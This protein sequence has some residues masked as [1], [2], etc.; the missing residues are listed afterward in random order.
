MSIEINLTIWVEALLPSG[1]DGRRAE[2]VIIYLEGVNEQFINGTLPLLLFPLLWRVPFGGQPGVKLRVGT[3]RIVR[4]GCVPAVFDE[5]DG[6]AAGKGVPVHRPRAQTQIEVSEG[7]VVVVAREEPVEA[8]VVVAEAHV[9]VAGGRSM[10]L[11][12]NR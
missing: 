9:V 5:A 11:A 12:L 1:Q 6:V 10:R 8:G 2:Y 7:T 3:H 4:R